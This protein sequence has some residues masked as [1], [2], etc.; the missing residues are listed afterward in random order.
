MVALAAEAAR[1]HTFDEKTLRLRM[2]E[3]AR[4]SYG[5]GGTVNQALE[6]G[7]KQGV[8][9][10]MAAGILTQQ[11]ESQLREFRDRL[12]RDSSGADRKATERLERASTDRLM[13][14]ARLDAVAIEDPDTHL[15]GLAQSLRNSGLPTA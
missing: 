13:L 2:A 12:T 3:I 4:K 14:D 9:H 8:A 5:D 6:E 15:D 1:T 7:W 10:S 11:E